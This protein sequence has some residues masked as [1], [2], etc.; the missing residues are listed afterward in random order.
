MEGSFWVLL[1]RVWGLASGFICGFMGV[2]CGCFVG[3]CGGSWLLDT[4]LMLLL[5]TQVG[6]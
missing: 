6:C 2:M 1:V 3:F 4:G 5:L